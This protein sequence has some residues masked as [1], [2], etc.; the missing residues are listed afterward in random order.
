LTVIAGISKH[1]K[2]LQAELDDDLLTGKFTYK[3]ISKTERER[4]INQVLKKRHDRR[5]SMRAMT[6]AAQIDT[7]LTAKRIGDEVCGFHSGLCT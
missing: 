6:K 2:E 5:R 4:L 3:S 7:K 1:L